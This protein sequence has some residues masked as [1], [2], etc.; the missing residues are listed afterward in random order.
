MKLIIE[1]WRSFLNEQSGGSIDN[2]IDQMFQDK[3]VLYGKPWGKILRPKAKKKSSII[4]SA[5]KDA[6]IGA[7]VLL[8]LIA[9]ES[10]FKPDAKAG[11]STATGYTQILKAARVEIYEKKIGRIW[12]DKARTKPGTTKQK[13]QKEHFS[14]LTLNE[15][16]LVRDFQE[17]PD[18]NIRAG[19]LYLSYLIKKHRLKH[20]KDDKTSEFSIDSTVGSMPRALCEYRGRGREN[21]DC[22]YYKKIWN[23]LDYNKIE[24]GVK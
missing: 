13:W 5:A 1:N 3:H 9:V 7:D 16:E 19:A 10:S 22:T 14:P 4:A 23:V 11:S 15:A 8:A 6:G 24:K 21:T 2:T 18:L 20:Q 12:H 17:D